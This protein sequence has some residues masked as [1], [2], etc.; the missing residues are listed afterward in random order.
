M[1]HFISFIII[2]FVITGLVIFIDRIF[3]QEI[4]GAA[5]IQYPIQELGNCENKTACKSY[6]D[7]PENIKVCVDFAERNSLMP[8]E[9]IELAKKFIATEGKGPGGCR[10]RDECEA[11]CDDIAHIDECV[12]F[13]EKNNLIPLKELGEA[14][15][16]QAAIKRG[17]KPPPC[18]NKKQCD[19]YC[20]EPDHMEECII[21]G[22][23][24]GFIQGKELE[25]VQKMIAALKR[26][27]KP[28]PCRGKEACDEYCS[29]PVN[30]EI[31]V[32]FAMEAGF[33]SEQEKADSQKILM[34]FKR[35]VKPPSCRGKRECD[36]Y[37]SQEEHFEEC[38]N[39]AEAAGLA[40]AEEVAMARRT[41]GKGPGGCRG[42]KECEVFC[43]NP[44]NQET[45]FNFAKENGMI[46]EGD[47]KM[48]EIDK[49]QFAETIA[50]M[51]QG[52]VDCLMPLVGMEMFEKFKT[53]AAMPSRA[54]GNQIR[55]CFEKIGPPS[56]I[57]PI[58]GGQP[59]WDAMMPTG[60][61][62]VG[63]GGC[64]GSEECRVYCESHR[65]ECQKF[66]PGP[67]AINP[68]G[69]IMPQQ[70]GP[71]GCKGP[72]ECK[73]YC[74]SHLEEC[75]N[76]SFDRSRLFMPDAVVP[77]D[78]CEGEACQQ[79]RNKIMPSEICQGRDCS[80]RPPLNRPREFMPPDT[81]N[82]S[83]PP[84]TQTS[85]ESFQPLFE[86]KPP[87]DNVIPSFENI[88]PP[89]PPPPNSSIIK[90]L[91]ASILNSFLSLFKR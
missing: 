8:Q 16:V 50:Q 5:D 15:K 81:N 18:A 29:N 4:I 76:F 6:C 69:Q 87:I 33:I 72:E 22:V 51:P 31:C 49:Q 44:D 40:P 2:S 36:I 20:G 25:D 58:G 57:V 24:A 65:E 17:V 66:Q 55:V 21:F 77:I 82:S 86:Q 27:I 43:N 59:V 75:R 61:V 79:M 83:Y 1:K 9:E 52:V 84:R 23:E 68:A 67:G 91:F 35:G 56:G 89:P 60:D 12:N 54:I 62:R 47:L 19:V 42:K 14:K 53:G 38:V 73:F 78:L 34:A 71:G 70:A 90:F 88:A 39:F 46:P 10:G 13:A 80:Q 28:P 11:Y 30:I 63:P 48:M 74:Q 41:G 32:N 64:K 45:C 7:E 85:P 37:C 3:A 26:G